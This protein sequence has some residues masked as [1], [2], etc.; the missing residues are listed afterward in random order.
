MTVAIYREDSQSPAVQLWKRL[1]ADVANH[2][3]WLV[4]QKVEP[5]LCQGQK[6]FCLMLQLYKKK[7][8]R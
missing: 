6:V 8:K 5:G 1:S 3:H 4:R 2:I 7:K